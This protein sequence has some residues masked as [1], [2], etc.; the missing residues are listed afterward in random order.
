[1]NYTELIIKEAPEIT[2]ECFEWCKDQYFAH[3]NNL[4][5]EA[6]VIL[7]LALISLFAASIIYSFSEK[8]IEKTDLTED[9]LSKIYRLCN[10]FAMYLI[11]G[12][13]VWFI[14]FR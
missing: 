10:T 13:F 6:M 1:M 2:K 9:S 8:I 11:I 12:F 4:T 3:Q 14:W 7:A 5:V